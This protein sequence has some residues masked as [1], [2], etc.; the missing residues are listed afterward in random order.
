MSFIHIVCDG[1]VVDFHLSKIKRLANN[2][3]NA[4]KVFTKAESDISGG[5]T[6]NSAVNAH[7]S[8]G[9]PVILDSDSKIPA[10]KG[11][12]TGQDQNI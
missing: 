6:P 2:V 3:T 5:T 10:Q 11:C 12:N 4:T 9:L 1:E 7:G 8:N